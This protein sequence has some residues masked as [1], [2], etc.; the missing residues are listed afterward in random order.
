MDIAA[1]VCLSVITFGFMFFLVV[2]AIGVI[3]SW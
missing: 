3:R 1:I 2:A